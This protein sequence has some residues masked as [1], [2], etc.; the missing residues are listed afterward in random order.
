MDKQKHI[1]TLMVAGMLGMTLILSGCSDYKPPVTENKTP[2][3]A[4]KNGEVKLEYEIVKRDVN[5]ATTDYVKEANTKGQ[6][7]LETAANMPLFKEEKLKALISSGLDENIIKDI[8]RKIYKDEIKN[9]SRLDRISLTIYDNKEYVETNANYVGFSYWEK[10][11]K[12]LDENDKDVIINGKINW[13]YINVDAGNKRKCISASDVSDLE[14]KIYYRESAINYLF[15]NADISFEEKEQ[16]TYSKLSKEFNLP[17]DQLRAI[18][19]KVNY[20]NLTDFEMQVYNALEK[21]YDDWNV[22][23]K[24]T[25][26]AISE[27]FRQEVAKQFKVSTDEA[28]G[29]YSHAYN[30]VQ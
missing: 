3:S 27:G 14:R 21:K 20:A 30:C 2:A 23:G 22:S 18:V 1:K 19:T 5:D 4:V 7:L 12:T 26:P 17:E 10:S 24:M 15:D 29:I 9:D 28:M 13:S 11:D 8:T 6:G 25:S 16:K